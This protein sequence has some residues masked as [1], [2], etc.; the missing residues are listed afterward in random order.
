MFLETKKNLNVFPN[1]FAQIN[2]LTSMI[3][4]S[5]LSRLLNHKHNV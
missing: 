1:T 4:Y 3:S 5:N 2:P